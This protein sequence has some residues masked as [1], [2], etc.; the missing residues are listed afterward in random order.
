[1]NFPARPFAQGGCKKLVPSITE[2]FEY[3]QIFSNV[4]H[5][6]SNIFKRFALVFEYFQTFSNVSILLILPNRYNL[7][8]QSP[9]LTQKQTSPPK[10]TPFFSHFSPI[11]DI[12]TR[13]FLTAVSPEAPLAGPSHLSN[14]HRFSR[15]IRRLLLLLHTLQISPARN[16]LQ[17]V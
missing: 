6:F 17:R 8:A 11:S 14:C 1:M 5:Q 12:S 2:G 9:F 10:S 15:R 7:T 13:Q 16:R 4:S 3:F